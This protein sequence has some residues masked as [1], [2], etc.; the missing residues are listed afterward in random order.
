[1]PSVS[2][3]AIGSNMAAAAAT[4]ARHGMNESIARLSTGIR[5]MYGGDAAGYSVGTVHSAEAKSYASSTRNIENGISY[6][7]TG[8]SVLLE[9]ANLAQRIR[10]LAIADD[11]AALLDSNQIAALD[12]EAALLGDA[13]DKILDNTKFNGVEILDSAASKSVAI[14]YSGDASSVTSTVGPSQ[15]LTA[16]AGITDA[17]GADTTAD[18]F[19]GTVA[20][21]LGNIAADLTALKA[22]QGAASA[23]SANLSAA[24]ARIMDTDYATETASLTKNSIL[25]QAALSMAAQA[26]NAQSAILS[27]LQ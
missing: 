10:E 22:F 27:V 17:T 4:K 19:L 15:A 12:A 18:T 24:S 26:N 2:N 16:M 21:A 8:E 1:M 13:I 20:A 5:A 11:N 7:Q 9:V 3:V 25:N 14:N 6:A 23:T